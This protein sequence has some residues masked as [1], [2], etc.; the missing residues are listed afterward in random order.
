MTKS[1]RERNPGECRRASAVRQKELSKMSQAP[2]QEETQ[3]FKDRALSGVLL[4]NGLGVPMILLVLAIALLLINALLAPG[5]APR[6]P[7]DFGPVVGP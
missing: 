3:R 7:E 5:F 1:A 6:G 4:V 2:T